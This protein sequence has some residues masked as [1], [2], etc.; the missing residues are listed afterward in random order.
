MNAFERHNYV[1][2]HNDLIKHKVMIQVMKNPEL[3]KY[4]VRVINWMTPNMEYR[5]HLLKI[6]ELK[7]ELL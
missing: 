2:I 7:K 1:T 5:Q 3:Y 6:E 4:D